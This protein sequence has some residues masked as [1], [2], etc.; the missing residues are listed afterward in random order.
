M[1]AVSHCKEQYKEPHSNIMSYKRLQSLKYTSYSMYRLPH[2][3]R[4]S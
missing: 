2:A 3:P 4:H 1:L